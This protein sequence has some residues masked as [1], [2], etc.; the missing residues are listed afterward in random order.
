MAGSVEDDLTKK[1]TTLIPTTLIPTLNKCMSKAT[2]A[3]KVKIAARLPDRVA[4]AIDGWARAIYFGRAPCSTASF[5]VRT[6]ANH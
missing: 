3:A 6:S 4:L 5:G 1:Y 2:K